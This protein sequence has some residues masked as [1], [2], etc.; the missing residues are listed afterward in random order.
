MTTAEVLK[1]ALQR[2]K[3]I[4]IYRDGQLI[5]D[6]SSLAA[7]LRELGSFLGISL[8]TKT[9]ISVTA[10]RKK[11]GREK[12]PNKPG[13]LGTKVWGFFGRPIYISPP[14]TP[15]PPDALPEERLTSA[16]DRALLKVAR[17][18]PITAEEEHALIIG[19][20]LS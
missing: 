6:G 17:G 8:T 13:L 5:Y 16:R 3:R 1:L 4:Q 15:P 7:T 12:A 18:I 2:G 11:K 14:F 19:E 10:N 20:Q 9:G